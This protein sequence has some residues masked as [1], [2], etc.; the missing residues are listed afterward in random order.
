MT[1]RE[2]VTAWLAGVLPGSVL[3]SAL[4]AAGF[5]RRTGSLVYSRGDAE[6]EQRFKLVFDA[7]PGYELTALAHLLP[8]VVLESVALHELVQRMVGE[9]PRS[10]GLERP[11]VMV[12]Q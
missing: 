11:P 6:V 2:T 9:E 5:T 8:Q 12:S 10:T 1:N 7:K 3:E 4:C